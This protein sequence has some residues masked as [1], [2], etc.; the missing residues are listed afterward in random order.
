[1]KRKFDKF[2]GA[3]EIKFR[4]WDKKQKGF[5]AGFNLF[6][7]HDYYTRGVE[8]SI[9]RYDSEW[10][11]SEIELM[12]YTGLNDATKWEE[13]TESEQVAWINCGGIQED[14]KGKLIYEGDII[15]VNGM[16]NLAVEYHDGSFQAG[17]SGQY[18]T[19]Y[20]FRVIGNIHR[21][22]ELLK[23]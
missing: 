3:R 14:W 9:K 15:A 23:P 8:P 7:F 22:P 20:P 19:S 6:S 5:I 17:S 16:E 10:K 1:V 18:L 4:A 12:Q 13:L 2:D 11:L 21:N